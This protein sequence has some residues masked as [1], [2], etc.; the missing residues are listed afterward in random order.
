MVFIYELAMSSITLTLSGNSSELTA[1]YCPAIDLSDGDYVCG[2]IDFQ[3]FNTI[4]NIDESNNLFCL[5]NEGSQLTN[6]SNHRVNERDKKKFG[7]AIKNDSSIFSITIPTGSYEVDDLKRHLTKQLEDRNIQFELKE[8]KNTLQCEIM[9]S[10]PIDFSKSNTIGPLL[11]FKEREVLEKN[12]VHISKHPADILKVNVIRVKCNIIT[13]SYF[14]H[15]PSHTIHEFS[16]RVSPGYKIVEVP[17]NVIYF[18]VTVRNIHTL[19][20]SI[21]DQN[22]KLID[23]RE[24][25]ITVRLHIKKLS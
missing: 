7:S 4:P 17:H 8:N 20:L 24:E 10:K 12:K 13:G 14:N 23:F 9:C 25:T 6:G 21:V 11:G 1:D 5:R 22:N 15:Q 19:T 2:L 16:P 18:P 3:T